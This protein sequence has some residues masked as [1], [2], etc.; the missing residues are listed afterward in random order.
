MP[1]SHPLGGHRSRHARPDEF[2]LWQVCWGLARL[3]ALM[4]KRRRD[5]EPRCGALCVVL[6]AEVA[7]RWEGVGVM[8]VWF[9][10]V[11][12]QGSVRVCRV[13]CICL[14]VDLGA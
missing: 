8:S 10:F 3:A 12:V 2:A 9:G 13:G 14:R 5:R 7:V 6:H 1:A 11:W 4:L